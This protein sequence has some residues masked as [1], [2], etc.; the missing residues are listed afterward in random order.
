MTREAFDLILSSLDPAAGHDPPSVDVDVLNEALRLARANGLFLAFGRGLATAGHELPRDHAAPWTEEL[1]ARGAYERT[2]ELLEAT[3]RG[4]GVPF[5]VIKNIWTVEHVPRDVDI[6]VRDTDLRAFLGA[7]RTNGCEV[8]YDDDAEISVLAHG[9]LRIDVYTRIHYLGRDFLSEEALAE[10]RTTEMLNGLRVPTVRADIAY[11]LNSIHSL[12]GH[13]ALTLL[14]LIDLRALEARI[15]DL[16]S[17]R[18]HAERFGWSRTFDAWT[19]HL[20]RLG[21]RF[22]QNGRPPAFPLR[23]G[24]RFIRRA[25]SLLDGT[26]L[27]LRERIALQASLLWDDVVFASE[28]AGFGETVRRSP[29]ATGVANAAGHRLRTLRG[30]RKRSERGEG[31]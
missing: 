17:A 21:V 28:G 24:R 14:D 8:L 23:H 2:F 13:G 22:F 3:S 10:S 18:A 11:A 19:A 6:F 12:L 7:L 20:E 29:V 26:P 4:S 15:G 9:R 27:D 16:S 1:A 30:D 31:R 25:V 5:S